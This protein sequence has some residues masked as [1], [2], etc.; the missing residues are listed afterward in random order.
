MLEKRIR[1]HARQGLTKMVDGQIAP[2]LKSSLKGLTANPDIFSTLP[3]RLEEYSNA[4]SAYD[5]SIPAAMEGSKTAI[6]QKKK[7]RHEAIRLY[8]VLAHY[9]EHQCNDDMATF[10]LSGFQAAPS[11]RAQTPPVSESIRKIEHGANSGQIEVTLMPFHRAK[12]YELRW[13]PVSA[14]GISTT[15]MTR[16][17]THIR[18]AAVISDLIPGTVYAFQVRALADSHFTDW[19]DSVTLM[20]T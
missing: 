3:I 12:S 1:I 5:E 19:S 11:T 16:S 9:V 18:P 8:T 4:I 17:L 14:G 15:W 7:L 20:C 6:E 10:L 2:L 13:A